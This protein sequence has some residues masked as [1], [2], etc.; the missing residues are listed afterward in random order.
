MEL[1]GIPTPTG[2]I[3]PLF[4]LPP[5]P[6]PGYQGAESQGGQGWNATK[7]HSQLAGKGQALEP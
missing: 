6:P 7:T 5:T 4:P 2:P 1:G 3:R